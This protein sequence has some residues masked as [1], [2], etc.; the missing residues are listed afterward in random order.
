MPKEPLYLSILLPTGL[1]PV[2]LLL[3]FFNKKELK[4]LTSITAPI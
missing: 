4:Y 2:K 3:A 1:A